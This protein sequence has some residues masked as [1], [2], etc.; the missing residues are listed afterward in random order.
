MNTDISKCVTANSKRVTVIVDGQPTDFEIKKTNGEY[1]LIELIPSLLDFTD[2]IRMVELREWHGAI[3][4]LYSCFCKGGYIGAGDLERLKVLGDKF[5][6][7]NYVPFTISTTFRLNNYDF[8]IDPNL[9]D[10]QQLMLAQKKM[11][12]M[13][14][15]LFIACLSNVTG[16]DKELNHVKLDCVQNIY[17][18]LKHDH[19][20]YD[21][22]IKSLKI[23]FQQLI[24]DLLKHVKIEPDNKK[25][26]DSSAIIT[27]STATL[28]SENTDTSAS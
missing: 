14:H 20:I 11:T 18:M 26:S 12:V 2:T 13:K 10:D 24:T 15:Q 19:L 28:N 1:K 22:C 7:D 16:F 3:F 6:N 4:A 27:A 25:K 23:Q 5:A 21:M 8:T 17:Y 9:D